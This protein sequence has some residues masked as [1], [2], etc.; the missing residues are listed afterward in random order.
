MVDDNIT[1]AMLRNAIGWDAP[2]IVEDYPEDRRGSSCLILAWMT[3]EQPLH[4]V[5]AYWSEIPQV[6]TVYRPNLERWHEDYRTRR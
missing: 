5:V 3:S 2:E 4:A 6:I 1:R